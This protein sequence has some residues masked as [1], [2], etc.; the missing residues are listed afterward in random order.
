MEEALL[1]GDIIN[2]EEKRLELES[3]NI[4]RDDIRRQL[5]DKYRVLSKK[6]AF[7]CR[8]CDEPVN[9]NLTKEEGRPFYFKHFDGKECSYSENTKIYE[10]Q[11]ALHQ[12]KKRKDIGLTVFKEIL[13]GQL[14]PFGAV[15][16]RGYFYK[17]K[18]SFIPDFI[19]RF[20]NSKEQWALD[21]YTSIAEGSYAQN[22]EK[23]IKAYDRE[24]FKA[25]SFIDAFW[26]AIDHETNKGTLL[27]PEM[28]VTRKSQEDKAWDQ[29]LND[30]LP[31]EFQD[32]VSEVIDLPFP[33]DT[34]SIAY[35][36]IDSRFCKIIRFVV[37]QRHNRNVTFLRLSEPIIALERALTI[38]K[39][40]DDFLL[41]YDNEEELRMAFIHIALDKKE[42]AELEERA[43]L[44]ALEKIE[45]EEEER[46]A[47]LN[48]L[49][50]E[51]QERVKFGNEI[52]SKD[53]KQ[54]EQEMAQRAEEAKSRPIDMSP[55]QWEWYKKT[56]R[57]YVSREKGVVQRQSNSTLTQIEDKYVKHQREKFKEKLLTHPI[58][59]DQFI[60]G[61]PSNWRGFI[62]KWINTH[63]KD[64][65]L[66][67][68][69]KE[70][71]SVM[72]ASGITFNQNDSHIQHPVEE[73]L[74]FYQVGLRRDLKRKV[75]V[76][77]VD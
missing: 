8:C 27:S 29:F 28:L 63:Q 61:P 1:H 70:L 57:N 62:L 44:E 20:P 54:I 77:F 17:K 56:G 51:A 58:K 22:I 67:V 14:K 31:S 47:V 75:N 68:S 72:K 43:Q 34:R 69:M 3:E 21:Y 6:R 12:D 36:N 9:M 53:D 11:V 23:R 40:Q 41:H 66:I 33:A 18:L 73:F 2:I 5:N 65:S 55:E 15:I 25:F 4:S 26:I 64:G 13:E 45:Q 39:R 59:G 49:R 35:V 60:D 30:D 10:K 48:I 52:K 46:I 19:V 7:S 76:I 50:L 37:T 16:E 74:L 38:N 42:Q 71:L 32:I 24:G